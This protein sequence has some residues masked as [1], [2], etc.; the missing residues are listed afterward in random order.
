MNDFETS[1]IKPVKE[2]GSARVYAQLRDD[3]L[4]F[5][6]APGAPLDEV[7]L[8]ERFGLSRS[9]VREA[10]V[11]LQSEGFVVILPNRSTIVSPIDFRE[12]PKYID[13]LDLIQRATTRL[14]AQFRT[15]NEI[16]KIEK[17]QLEFEK[18]FHRSVKTLDSSHNIEANFNFHM[19]IAKAG[20]NEYFVNFYRRLLDEGRRMLHFHFEFQALSEHMSFEA[21]TIHHVQMIEAIRDRDLDKADDIA[22]KHAMQF[23]GRFLDYY[24]Q[25][26]TSKMKLSDQAATE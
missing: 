12:V 10:L 11:R 16:K 1:S 9:P 18:A 17:L 20:K 25:S 23:K 14:A 13:A 24:D 26:I 4:R 3:I 2:T 22:H 7:G 5:R 15:P 6:L 21:V 19:A 8:G